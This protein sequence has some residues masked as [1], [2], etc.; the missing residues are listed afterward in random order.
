MGRGRHPLRQD[1]ELES[2]EKPKRKHY[3]PEVKFRQVLW[4]RNPRRSKQGDYGK[5]EGQ[6]D[7]EPIRSSRNCDSATPRGLGK[8]RKGG[9]TEGK[10]YE[11]AA[12]AQSSGLLDRF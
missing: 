6:K 12:S 1:S 7:G 4:G 5:R 10:P 2:E 9:E 11:T 8:E 3:E